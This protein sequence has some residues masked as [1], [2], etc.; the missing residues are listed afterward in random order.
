LVP[1]LSCQAGPVVRSPRFTLF[2]KLCALLSVV[3]IMLVLS[4]GRAMAH[5]QL[6]TTQPSANQ[7][8]QAGKPPAKVTLRF[9]E[10]VSASANG[11]RLFDE[12]GERITLAETSG[13]G[14][15][16]EAP[17]PRLA[18]GS[19]IVVWAVVSDDG[20][21]VRG[22]YT[23]TVGL[24][25][26]GSLTSSQLTEVGETQISAASAPQ[27]VQVA[28][29]VARWLLFASL[30]AVFGSAMCMAN[31]LPATGRRWPVFAGTSAIC[32]ALFVVLLE[33]PYLSGEPINRVFSPTLISESLG[34][35]TVRAIVGAAAIGVIA[36][37]LLR[38]S[39]SASAFSASTSL[40]SPIATAATAATASTDEEASLKKWEFLGVG[41]VGSVLLASTGHAMAG[42]YSSLALIATAVHVLAAATWVAGLLHIALRGM[43][44][45][46]AVL[47]KW[48]S[49]AQ[50]SV[51]ALLVSGSFNSWRQL[52][53]QDALFD[54]RYGRVLIIK[55]AL[56]ALML[57]LAAQHRAAVR[58]DDFVVGRRVVV[59][60]LVGV[61]VLCF[62]SLLAS[63]IPA[64]VEIG[65]PVS[66]RL[67]SENLRN[68]L[69]VSPARKGRN[70]VHLYAFDTTG[71][72]AEIVDVTFIFTHSAT[73]TV[74]EVDPI[75]AGR[76]HEEARGVD[77]PLSGSWEVEAKV[78]INDFEV[79]TFP[80]SFMIR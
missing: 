29:G 34:R 13:S 21:P 2:P 38:R 6:E 24:P 35:T 44:R 78:Y 40:T 50:T 54:T 80:G 19:Y 66:L 47:R 11:I 45:N 49:L 20:H 14:L 25:K 42:P 26:A 60:A 68:D 18:D 10:T 27:Q 37:A 41:I 1:V 77:F 53:S 31:G 69:T 7:R 73:G 43:W 71:V 39:P 48:S 16:I 46:P 52:G 33:G 58:R 70:V 3:L 5:A 15:I 63:T 79:E 8:F 36:A 62:S 22:S 59:E 12:L 64:R 17:L 76:G 57:G 9:N 55:V 23:F 56:V 30:L 67:R 72:T 32:A 4:A 51:A 75:R 74:L 65:K 61:A 28:L